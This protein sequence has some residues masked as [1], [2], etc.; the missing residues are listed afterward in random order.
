MMIFYHFREICEI[1]II[2][3]LER[4]KFSE[5]NQEVREMTTLI[6]VIFPDLH[7]YKKNVFFIS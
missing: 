3:S 7:N 2:V 5:R 6:R 4:M 1:A